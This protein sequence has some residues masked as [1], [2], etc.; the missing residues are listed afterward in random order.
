V[1]LE[2]LWAGWRMPYVSSATEANEGRGGSTPVEVACVFCAIRDSD[3]PDS[4]TLVLWK[5]EEC[6]AVLNLYPYTSGHL[7]LLPN[8][9]VAE[10]EDI[11]PEE[12]S[13]LWRATSDAVRALKAAYEPQGINVGANLGR[14]A[15]AGIPGHFHLH[16]LP[17]WG[18]DTNFMTSVADARILPESLPDTWARLR[19]AWPS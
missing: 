7:L 6:F 12:G 1:S 16:V 15:G 14:A 5:G 10:V 13:G 8:R 19:D 17:R 18:G 4:E 2:R 11:S 3:E 9:H